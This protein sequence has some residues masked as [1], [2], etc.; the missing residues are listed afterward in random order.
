MLVKTPVY[1]YSLEQ[2]YP[3]P[4]SGETSIRFTIPKAEKVS[5][6]VYDINGRIVKVLVHGSRDAGTHTVSFNTGSLAG[7]I[8]YYRMK[9]GDFSQN[10]KTNCRTI[11]F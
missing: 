7:G 3:N 1:N 10:K 6:A 11:K 5:L 4:A 8:Y 9:A 2:N